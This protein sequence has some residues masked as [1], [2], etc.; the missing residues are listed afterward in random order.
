MTLLLVKYCN[1]QTE[2]YIS[3]LFVPGITITCYEPLELLHP[4]SAAWTV[5]IYADRLF[6]L[7]EAI[8]ALNNRNWNLKDVAC[9]ANA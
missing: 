6:T 9:S 1:I 8:A 4:I 5:A 2:R 3:V 7:S